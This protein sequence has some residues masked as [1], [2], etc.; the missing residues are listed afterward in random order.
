MKRRDFLKSSAPLAL[1]SM[2]LNGIPL[3][4]FATANML[5]S[6][7]CEASERVLVVVYLNGAND[8]VNTFIP[9]D[10]HA[11]YAGHRPNIYIPSSDLITLDT[12]LPS[13][14]YLGLNP[15]LSS[16]KTLY[17]AEKLNIIQGV[18]MPDPNRS[19]FKAQD[20]WFRGGDGQSGELDSGWIMRFLDNRYPDYAGIPFG[21]EPDPL[22]ISLGGVQETGYQS[23]NEYHYHI[24]LSG[25]DVAG[26][27]SLISSIGGLPIPNIPDTEHGDVLRYIVG[28]ENSVNVYSNQISNTFNNGSNAIAYPNNS[29]ADQLKTAARL[30]SGGSSTKVFLTQH[31]G[32][33]THANQVSSNSSLTGNHATLLGEMSTAIKAFQDDLEAL[34]LADRVLTVVFSEFG[35]KI[36]QNGNYGSDHGTLGSMVVI[37]NGVK[38]GV[39]GN[40]I[41]LNDLDSQGASEPSGMQHD[42]RQVFSSILKDW[43]GG[44]DN[45]ITT[46]FL[47]TNFNT[48]MLPIIKTNYTIGEDCVIGSTDLPVDVKIFLGGPFDANSNTMKDNLRTSNQLPDTE[49]YTQLG[50][51]VD[52]AGATIGNGVLNIGGNSTAIVDWVL[53]ELR[54]ADAPSSIHRAMVALV[55]RD[56]KVVACEDGESTVVFKNVAENQT[57]KLAVRHRNHLGAMA[58]IEITL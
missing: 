26:F 17:D 51:I 13:N 39:T 8:F 19:H 14:Q 55:R 48:N 42:Y 23:F 4:T 28:I 16:F 15:S 47:D 11:A 3:R 34:G 53:L 49:P 57:Y 40:N 10:Q 24:D 6:I 43:M 7:N 56:G 22:G 35:R 29:L 20:L 44:S 50:H 45:T 31:R 30:L 58:D 54:E 46:T 37:G 9:L 25:Q 5:A 52:N 1:S 2:L 21:N 27:Y 38:Q 18:G 36:I 32:Y 12:S 41:D 33:D